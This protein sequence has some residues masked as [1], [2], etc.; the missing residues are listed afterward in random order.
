MRQGQLYGVLAH[1]LKLK[2]QSA[3]P[4]LAKTDAEMIR[5][6]QRAVNALL[7]ARVLNPQADEVWIALVQLLVDVGQP[8][9]AQPLIDEAEESLKGEQ[10][11]ITL[12]TC[13]EL[14]NETEKAQ[15]KYEAAAKASPQNSRV[16]R[17]VAA[18]YLRTASSTW[19]SRFS[20]RSSRWKR[21]QRSPM[22]VGPAA[23]WPS[24]SRA[25]ETSIISA[26]AWR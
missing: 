19:P 26:K 5:M 7:K 11:P 12:A 15:A 14:L 2:A 3:K 17:Q 1:R 9:K 4:G 24:S 22:P 23:A 20:G 18:F 13:C 10:A 25:A 6:A 16:L 8:D 21:R